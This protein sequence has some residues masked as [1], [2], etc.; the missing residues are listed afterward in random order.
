MTSA[1]PAGE[2]AFFGPGHVEMM[3]H[4]SHLTFGALGP[5]TTV[6][7]HTWYPGR[8]RRVAGQAAS[9]ASWMMSSR[10]VW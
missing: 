10:A 2:L 5:G 1:D 7:W 3:T 9:P 4:V 6:W 8:R